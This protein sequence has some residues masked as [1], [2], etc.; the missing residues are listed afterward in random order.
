[1]FRRWSNEVERK[2][3]D[4]VSDKVELVRC[5]AP[6]SIET[7]LV[8]FKRVLSKLEVCAKRGRGQPADKGGYWGFGLSE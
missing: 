3:K 8:R 6:G 4:S 2:K 5:V 1:M 7:D